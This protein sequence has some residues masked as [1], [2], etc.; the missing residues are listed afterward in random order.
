MISLFKKEITQFFGSITGTMVSVVFLLLTGLFLWVFAGN[1]N[2]PDGGYATL[3]GLFEIAPWIY[4]FLIPAVTMR[5][6]ADEKRSGTMELL[7][8]RPVT[9]LQLILSKF[10]AAL[11]VVLI[12]L[13]PTLIYFVSVYF[14]GNPVG[15]V[16]TGAT[17]GSYTGLF[18]LAVIY[19]TIGLF[20]SSVTDNQVVAFILA[21]FLCFFWYSG[22]GFLAR[23]PLPSQFSS[24]ITSLGIDA[25]YESVSRGVLDSRD[26]LYFLLMAGFFILLT[27]I[28]LEWKRRP[29]KRSVNHLLVYLALI[30]VVAFI[31]QNNFFRV[32][33]TSEKRF[34]LSTQTRAL[35]K[36]VNAPVDAEIL[37]SGDLPPGFMKLQSAAIEKLR[38]LKIY[39]DQPIHIHITD[40]YD[41][42]LKGSD[43][44]K[45]F[46]SLLTMGIAPV[47]LRINTGQGVTTK[48]VFPTMILRAGGNEVAVNLL[49][50][51]P[52]LR[53]EENLISSIELLEYEFARGLKL[54]FQEK[55]ENVAFL[56]GHDELEEVQVHDISV[57]LSE[58]FNIRRVS[59]AGLLSV[60]DSFKAVIIANPLKPFPEKDK[61]AIDQYLMQGGRIMW[62]IDPVNV[63]LDSLSNG[64]S[65]M[66]FPRELN[67]D[68]QLFHYGVRINADLI[69]DIDCQKIKVNTA[70]EGQPPKYATAPWYFS[71]LL[72]PSQNHPI[73]KN[74]NRVLA[75]FVSS[76]DLVGETE[77]RKSTI[78]LTSSPYARSSQS[79][80]IVNLAMIDAPPSRDLF[81]KQF[82]PTGVLT[83]GKFTSVFKNRM[84]QEFG[85]AAGT[86]TIAES[87]ITKMIFIS[88]GGLIAN[89]VSYSGGKYIP[90]PLGF[91]K[92]S[93]ITFGNREFLV[94]AVHYL[95]DDSGLMELRSRTM[96]MRLLD[97]VK[98]R[99]QKL[100]WQLINVVLPVFI[101]LAGGIIFWWLRRRHYT[102]QQPGKQTDHRA[103]YR[104]E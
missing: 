57:S 72:T 11:A 16:D 37:L 80:M 55:R 62:L 93:N 34:T 6:F 29:L 95:C 74:V 41:V 10:L 47:N 60:P 83:E 98:L 27:R 64:M 75:E 100:F 65:T 22:F 97:K 30:L 85:M 18:F 7:L 35:L 96:Q 66:A 33:F 1:F 45:Y 103:G 25:H 69:Q 71:P 21:V 50:N 36:K 82:I 26:L 87:R 28:V 101:I 92:V 89:K 63:S 58:N 70:L 20:T 23:L 53:D 42:Q 76:I 56:T 51:D 79:P 102:R 90:L 39:C 59:C 48:T 44:K 88:D 13:L 86:P 91:D 52:F 24:A 12:T 104:K 61:F 46:E 77:S 94:N 78:I 31:S 38:D 14:L 8:A 43:K 67:L 99:E 54:L 15:C 40:P 84:V 68:D 4:L 17:W 9:E 3:D 73:G 2:I 32:D 5:M 49:K 19:L 81:S